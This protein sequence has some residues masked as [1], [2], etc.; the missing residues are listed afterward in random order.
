MGQVGK[1]GTGFK[2][3][4]ICIQTTGS[5]IRSHGYFPDD[6]Q[7][8][9]SSDTTITVTSSWY[10]LRSPWGISSN[11]WKS[12]PATIKSGHTLNI[13]LIIFFPI[14]FS[15]VTLTPIPGWGCKVQTAHQH[16][17]VISKT[18]FR[19]ENQPILSKLTWQPSR[20]VHKRDNIG[21]KKMW[22]CK[23]S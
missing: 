19:Y 4:Q 13:A 22:I 5:W 18:S 9:P 20:I 23:V 2:A 16:Q 8:L 7:I 3:P 1:F 12:I 15:W 21:I 10:F 11:S 14:L 6:F 17:T